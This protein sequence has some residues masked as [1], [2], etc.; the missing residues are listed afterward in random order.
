MDS[1]EGSLWENCNLNVR[2]ARLNSQFA[3]LH[4]PIRKQERTH[5]VVM[6]YITVPFLMFRETKTNGNESNETVAT[7]IFVIVV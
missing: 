6:S 7:Q 1:L 2:N 3:P 4:Q 5:I